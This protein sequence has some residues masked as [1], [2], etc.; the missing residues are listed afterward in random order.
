VPIAV[1]VNF[2]PLAIWADLPF[3]RSVIFYNSQSSADRPKLFLYAFCLR[4]VLA[5]G[6]PGRF[7]PFPYQLD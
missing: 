4:Y 7:C 3:C 5:I 6:R 1:S 2:L